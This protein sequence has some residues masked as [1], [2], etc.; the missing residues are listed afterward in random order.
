MSRPP[1]DLGTYGR[2]SFSTAPSGAVTAKARFRDYDGRTRLVERS[3]PTK[4]AAERALKRA[5]QDRALPASD[6]LGGESTTRVLADSWWVDFQGKGRAPATVRRYREVLDWYVLP[7]LGN[8][9]LREARVGL[10]EQTLRSITEQHGAA[11]AKLCQTV[12]RQMFALAVR[13]EAIDRNPLLGV[14]SVRVEHRPVQALSVEQ[15]RELRSRVSGDAADMLD[16][17]LAT[18]CR[19]GE[20][21][22]LRWEDVDLEASPPRISITGTVVRGSGGLERQERP[23]S[24]GSMHRLILPAFGAAALAGRDRWSPLVFP[25]ARGGLMDPNN[26]RSRWREAM[27][28]AGYPQVYPHMI[29]ATV[30]TLLARASGMSAATAQLGHASEAVTSK[31]YVERLAEAPDMSAHLAAFGGDSVG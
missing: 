26:A 27:N 21:L 22:A 14:S 2:I 8:V 4:A 16:V 1:L 29:R 15:V 24:Q 18:G 10:M 31:H 13:R 30:G 19:I 11:T 20:V 25:N 12:L 6:T 5:F 7:R 3:G 28:A 9:R 17:L 23:K